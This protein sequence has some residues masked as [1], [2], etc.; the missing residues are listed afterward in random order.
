MS[1]QKE[2]LEQKLAD[3]SREQAPDGWSNLHAVI[4]KKDVTVHARQTD[5]IQPITSTQ[6]KTQAQEKGTHL[7]RSHHAMKRKTAWIAAWST[8]AAIVLV[9]AGVVIFQ[10]MSKPA[11]VKLEAGKS[12]T[13]ANGTLFI[14]EISRT[15]LRIGM[16]P[17]AESKELSF[18]DLP[19]IFGREPIPALPDGF[20]PDTETVSAMMYRSGPVFLMNG[21]T[22]STDPLDPNAARIT[23]DLNDLGELP[24]TDCVFGSET[25][26]TLE[27]VEMLVGIE[28]IE[29][30]AGSIEMYTAQFVAN[31]IGYRIRATNM[32]GDQFLSILEAVV[33]G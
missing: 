28:T 31:N 16:P 1:K 6:P 13:V 15:D 9:L 23:F 14:N 30:E 3:L 24:L 22:F 26:S 33:K 32:T 25:T 4:V 17:D 20:K 5:R 27:G 29:G 19:G 21:I 8:A 11:D 12:L 2:K 10:L 18:A 7:K